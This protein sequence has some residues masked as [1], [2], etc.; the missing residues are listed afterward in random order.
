ME[1]RV[2]RVNAWPYARRALG[3]AALEALRTRIPLGWE[4]VLTAE[5]RSGP[6]HVMLLHTGTPVY[7]RWH[8]DIAAGCAEALAILPTDLEAQLSA[9]LRAVGA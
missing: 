2:S 4:L 9:S 7:D 5:R 1:R 8:G 3:N 6:F